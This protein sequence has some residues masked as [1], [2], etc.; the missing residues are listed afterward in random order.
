MIWEEPD[1]S[2]R[3]TNAS[4]R[5]QD[6]ICTVTWQ[7]S[8]DMEFVYVYLFG[9]SG[10]LPPEQL[11]H[12]ELKLVTREEYKALQGY[13][14]RMERIG[15]YGF[16]IFPCVYRDGRITPVRQLDEDNVVRFSGGRA[17]IH[18]SVQYASRWFSPYRTARIRVF[19]EIPVPREALC[20]VKKQGSPPRSRDDG[21][22][23]PF[24]SDFAAGTTT[25][26]GVD[27]GKDEHIRLFLSDGA[28]YGGLYELVCK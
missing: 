27:I 19:C 23:Y 11:S 15:P 25:L 3:I 5:L 21:I 24:V 8:R 18:Y 13:T 17:Q 4:C 7:W 26:P 28:K 10:E 2:R 16:R 22:V 14:V 6:G 1:E 9:E 20:Y 12:V